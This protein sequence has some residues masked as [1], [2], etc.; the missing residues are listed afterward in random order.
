M[1]AKKIVL[2]KILELLLYVSALVVTIYSLFVY[3]YEIIIHSIKDQNNLIWDI[4]RIISFIF[5]GIILINPLKKYI[6][7]II[8]S[9]QVLFI[10]YEPEQYI[11]YKDDI[12]PELNEGEYSE[13]MDLINR[14]INNEECNSDRDNYLKENY[15]KMIKK[16]L[17]IMDKYIK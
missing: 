13:V 2:K 4:I 11:I 17:D 6:K 3:C 16:A 14:I 15:P 1:N 5:V 8:Y 7:L 10:K 12:E 9:I